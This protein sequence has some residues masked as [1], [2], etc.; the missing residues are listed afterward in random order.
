MGYSENELPLLLASDLRRYYPDLILF[1]QHRLYTFASRL[2]GNPQ[3]AEDIVQEA[4]VGAYVSLQQYPSQR[5]Q[6]LKLRSWLYRVT[7]NVF[8][9]HAR[10]ARLHLVPLNLSEESQVLAIEESEDQR[11]EALFEQQERQQELEALVA[12]L[13]ERYRIAVTCYYFEQM[14]YR[15]VAELL[16]QPVGTVKSTVSRGVGILRNMLDEAEQERGKQKSWST[17]RP[18]NKKA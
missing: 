9:L 3:D 10:G 12:N 7:L 5:I 8:N 11:P 17:M 6:S 2:T 18:N 15:E 4:F 1:Y 16:D 14:N 13:P